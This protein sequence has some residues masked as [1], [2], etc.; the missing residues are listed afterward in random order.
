MR[1]V[2]RD[3]ID[4]ARWNMSVLNHEDFRHYYLTQY[5]DAAAA[6]WEAL[7]SDDYTF[8]WPLPFKKWGV[9]RLYQPTFTQQL[10]PVMHDVDEKKFRAAFKLVQTRYVSG[11]IKFHENI[12]STWLDHSIQHRN[13]ELSLDSPLPEL[14]SA[15]NRNVKSNLRKFEK[16]G[17]MVTNFKGDGM[18]TIH[19]FR[20]HKGCYLK[21]ADEQFYRELA[22]IFQKF[23]ELGQSEE[24]LA[25]DA[26]GQISGGLL[27]LTSNGRLLNLL[28]VA[29][30]AGR[31]IG[32]VHAI[33]D[34][35][36]S[37]HHGKAQ[38]LDFE[39]SNDDNLAFFYGS[40]GGAE[41]VYLQAE[42]SRFPWPLNRFL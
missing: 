13:I 4:D 6:D 37:E 23:N 20:E 39:G 40:F 3:Q 27:L 15:Y 9:K 18:K 38:V 42:W 35:L 32:A 30:P 26:N 34:R 21:E 5:L 11:R 14:R 7:I 17:G 19:L 25:H 1:F 33:I 28:S 29:N 22:H 31:K 24:W 41:H 10:G 16:A 8:L 36:I 2:S 12:D